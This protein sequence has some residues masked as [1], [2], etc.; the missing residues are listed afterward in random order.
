[1]PLEIPRR[2]EITLYPGTREERKVEV[3]I[4][5]VS[6]MLTFPTLT[7]PREELAITYQRGLFPPAVVWIPKDEATIEAVIEA[8]RKDIEARPAAPERFIIP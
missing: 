2:L 4:I 1:V 3:E 8:I 7:T 6:Q 5:D